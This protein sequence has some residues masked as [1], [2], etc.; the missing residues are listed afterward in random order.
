M[1][2]VTYKKAILVCCRNYV[3]IFDSKM[4]SVASFDCAS[5]RDVA[6]YTEGIHRNVHVTLEYS[7]H[8]LQC[9]AVRR[10]DKVSLFYGIF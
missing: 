1:K 2:K 7:N 9:I 4:E 3:C 10:Q 6:A 5:F 8:L